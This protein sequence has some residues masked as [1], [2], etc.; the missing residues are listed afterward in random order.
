MTDDASAQPLLE[1]LNLTVRRDCETILDGVNF[2]V[3]PGSIHSLIGPNGAGKTTLLTAVLGQT[4]FSGSIRCHWRGSG[5]VGYVPQGFRGERTIPLTVADFL[6]LS[7]QR[8]PACL[9]VGA[10]TRRTIAGLLD[11]VGLAGLERRR[12]GVLSGGEFQRL[13]LAN[14]IDPVPELLLLD[15]PAASLDAA[16]VRR[17]EEILLDLRKQS[18][19]TVFMVSHDLEQVRRVADRVTVLNRRIVREAAPRD[20]AVEDLLAAVGSAAV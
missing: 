8:R 19:V 10:G 2:S 14:A 20:L 11:R 13:M 9:G 18:G 16:A 7:R 15:E 4:A 1:I 17:L 3:L 5:R 6:A 12:I